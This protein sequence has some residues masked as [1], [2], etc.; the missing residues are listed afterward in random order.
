MNNFGNI[1][2]S[3]PNI[4]RLIFFARTGVGNWM[5]SVECSALN[6]CFATFRP[7]E[8]RINFRKEGRP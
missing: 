2:H 1:Q 6:V 4:Q 8:K 5:F 3:T 7:T